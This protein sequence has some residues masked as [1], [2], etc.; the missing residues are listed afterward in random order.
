MRSS[1]SRVPSATTALGIVGQL[2]HVGAGKLADADVR[3]RRVAERERR[4]RELVLREPLDMREIAELGQRVG[5][6]RDRRLRQAGALGDLAIAEQAFGR[7]EGAQH[8]EAARQRR[9]EFAVA[10]AQ[11]GARRADG[12]TSQDS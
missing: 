7:R 12:A 2:L 10:R 4:G 5:E 1:R 3:E 11:P 8:F 6:P 9:D